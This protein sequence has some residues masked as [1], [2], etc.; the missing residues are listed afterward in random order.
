MHCLCHPFNL[1]PVDISRFSISF[2]NSPL[3][4]RWFGFY[5]SS[6]VLCATCSSSRGQRSTHQIYN[7]VPTLLPY[8]LLPGRREQPPPN[9]M[10]HR[11]WRHNQYERTLA[12][13]QPCCRMQQSAAHERLRYREPCSTFK[14]DGRFFPLSTS[15][16]YTQQTFCMGREKRGEADMA[17]ARRGT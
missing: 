12:T 14:R 6:S 5:S 11:R 4:C 15:T 1:D 9:C 13:G 16:P 10:A 8:F 3:R 17:G 7:H 2:R